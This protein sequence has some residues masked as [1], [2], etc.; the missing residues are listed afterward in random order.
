MK[1]HLNCVEKFLA[2]EMGKPSNEAVTK[3]GFL[4]FRLVTKPRVVLH[5]GYAN[6]PDI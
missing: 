5:L 1:N 4:G 6:R 2:F 3:K